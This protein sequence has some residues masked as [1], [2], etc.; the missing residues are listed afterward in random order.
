MCCR[1]HDLSA[2][3]QGKGNGGAIRQPFPDLCM[4]LSMVWFLGDTDSESGGTPHIDIVVRES[5]S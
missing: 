2:Y 5:S 4:C 1:P 3:G